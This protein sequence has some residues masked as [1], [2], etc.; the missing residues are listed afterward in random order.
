MDKTKALEKEGIGKLMWKFFVPAFIGVIA[1]ALYNIVDRVFI[2]QGVGSL[3]LSGIG[4]I[5]PVM[6]IVMGFGMLIGV[7]A[8]VLVSIRLGE[9]SRDGA[10]Q[11]LGTTLLL[12]LIVS[13]FIVLVVFLIKKP[14]LES[15]GATAETLDYANSYLNIILFGTF[16]TMPGYSLNNMIRSEGNARIA[17]Y[18]MLLSASVNILLDYLFIMVFKWGVEGA[19]WATVISMFVLFVWVFMHFRSSRSVINLRPE[20][21]RFDW[22]IAKSIIAIGMA[23]FAMQIASSV[24]QGLANKML[25]K[26]GGDIAVGAFSIVISVVSLVVMSVIAINM[27]AQP[28]IGF[29]FGAKVFVR[30]K[31][32]LR[33]ALITATLVSI[34]AWIFTQFFPEYIIMMFNDEDPHLLEITLRAIK[35]ITMTFPIIG[36]QIVAGNYFQAVGNAKTAMF[37]TLLRQVLVLIPL[38]FLLPEFYDLDGIWLSFPVSDTVSALVV[39]VFMIREWRRLTSLS[40]PELVAET[41][42]P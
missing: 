27:A 30:V 39:M 17:M 13:T 23:P 36:F 21:V 5:F 40:G 3:A 10:E 34:F 14:L 29:N 33:I 2:G 35:I 4:V 26:Y 41:V 42:N 18:S 20:L 16:F 28:I 11:V 1:N 12:I 32:T 6:L 9:R 15:F 37:L 25:I 31:K 7:G 22:S 8:G 24:V 19:A 38:L